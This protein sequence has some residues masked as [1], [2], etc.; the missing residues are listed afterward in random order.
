MSVAHKYP[1]FSWSLSRHKMLSGCPRKYFFSYY[2]ANGGWKKNASNLSKHSYRLKTLQNTSLLFGTSVHNQ[3]HQ[4]VSEP[5]NLKQFP[6]E[7][8]IIDNVRADLNKA[9]QQSKYH[10]EKWY[11]NPSQSTML[12][13][14][15]Y[16]NELPKEIIEEFQVKIPETAKNLLLSKTFL[17]LFQRRNQIELIVAEKFRCLEIGKIKIWVVMDLVLRDLENGKYVIVDF[18]TG[19]PSSDDAFQLILYSW[20]LQ[21]VYD[22]ESLDQIELRN[23]YLSNGETVTYSPKPFD[24]EKIKYL[25]HT[26]IERMQSYL[27]DEEQ[28]MPVELEAFEQTNNQKVCALCNF[29]ELC[30]R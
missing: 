9:Y 12:S 5:D 21:Q 20:F 15:Y 6:N 14:I 22:I 24:L 23:E 8:V 16:D 18:K 27:Q 2:G 3:V 17:D 10:Q 11:E 28:N 1:E 25:I 26:S 4:I 30:G 13:E 7:Q 29:R 19:K